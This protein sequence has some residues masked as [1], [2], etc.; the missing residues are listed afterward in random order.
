MAKKQPD[1]EVSS[2]IEVT[3]NEQAIAALAAVTAFLSSTADEAPAEDAET[4][5]EDATE[6]TAAEEATPPGVEI[7]SAETL[8]D[9]EQFPKEQVIELATSLNIDLAGKKIGELRSALV[10]LAKIKEESEDAP[11]ADAVN[12]LCELLGL[13]PDKKA[14][15]N[16][17]AVKAWVD[18]IGASGEAST[19]E[20]AVA[21]PAADDEDAVAE[22][23]A[24]DTEVAA[25]ED[26]VPEAAAG[27][28]AAPTAAEAD[29]DG[30]DREGIA[31]KFTKF[32]DSKTMIARLTAFN[33]VATDKIAFDAKK[34]ATLKPAYRKLVTEMV[35]SDATITEWGVAYFRD[36]GGWCCGLG[37]DELTPKPKG[38]KEQCGICAVTKKK[39]KLDEENGFVAIK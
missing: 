5:A 34:D 37:L 15:K 36:N 12:A 38:V 22:A 14:A 30:V 39:F 26:A 27:E 28:E 31:K 17:A 35:A 11:E 4:P 18:A 3:T 32:P 19:E 7:P 21:E 13:E 10:T 1:P 2:E 23:P 8:T 6:E 25:E 16:V 20:D 9:K 33:A 24:E 29:A